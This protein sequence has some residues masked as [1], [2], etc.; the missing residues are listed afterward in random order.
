MAPWLAGVRDASE[1]DDG[2]GAGE[3]A[4]PSPDFG[5]GEP[6]GSEGPGGS[7]GSDDFEDVV[8]PV[9]APLTVVPEP[10]LKLLPE[11]SSQVVMPAMVTANTRAAAN[12]GRRQVRTRAR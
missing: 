3:V 2:D 4:A 5:S 6:E 8:S 7:E 1:E 9:T 12:T 11:T 10:P